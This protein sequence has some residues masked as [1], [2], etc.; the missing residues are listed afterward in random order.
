V[1]EYPEGD[2]DVITRK[3]SAGQETRAHIRALRKDGTWIHL[4]IVAVPLRDKASRVTGWMS[5]AR[6]ITTQVAAFEALRESEKRLRET[7]AQLTFVL[8][9]SNDGTW[10]WHIPSGHVTYSRRWASMLGYDV[11]ELEQNVSVWERLVH[12]DDMAG[13]MASLQAHLTGASEH[14]ECE[15]RIRH[16]DGRWIW[17]LDR[18][19]VVERDAQGQP[20]RAAGTHTDVSAR[21]EA[22][23]ALRQSLA[24][25]ERLVTELRDALHSIK[26]LSSILPICAYCKK[27]R[28]DRGEWEQLEAY[29]S[30]HTDTLFSHGMCPDCLKQHW[31]R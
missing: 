25:N 9:G 28:D 24:D 6:D 18:G 14:Y 12:P 11:A 1:T 20:L 21:R 17:V 30:A 23:Q 27:I 4:D 10:D 15:H 22:E 3:L 8:E 7:T 31:G 13:V 2:G 5:V 26:Q 19:R 29:I 16:K